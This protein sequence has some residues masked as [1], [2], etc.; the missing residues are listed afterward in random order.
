LEDLDD[1]T[2]SRSLGSG[3]VQIS[4]RTPADDEDV[5]SLLSDEHYPKVS[6]CRSRLIIVLTGSRNMVG[7]GHSEE[8]V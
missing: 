5:R 4:L 2:T 1:G 8:V 3:S 7:S 6:N